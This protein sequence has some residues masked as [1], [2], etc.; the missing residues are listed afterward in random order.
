MT[1]RSTTDQASQL[2]A[3]RVAQQRVGGVMSPDVEA[4][5]IFES[6]AT[7]LLLKP[8]TA[9]LFALLARNGLQ[10]AIQTELAQIVDLQSAV[11]DLANASLDVRD[12][13]ELQTAI[14]ALSQLEQLSK[15]SVDSLQFKKF[16]SS[17]SN[18]LDGLSKGVKRPGAT[19]L[20]RPGSEALQD[21]L[22]GFI[23]LDTLHQDTIGRLYD[24][25]VG[26][27]NFLH[28]PLSTIIGLITASRARADIQDIVDSLDSTGLLPADRDLV[29]RLI[30]NRA[31]VKT[32]GNLP[33]LS[34]PLVDSLSSLPQGYSLQAVSDP[35]APSITGSA[36]PFTL[37]SAA[38]IS[39]SDG[40]SSIGPINFPQTTS[41][42]NNKAAIVSQAISYPITIAANYYLFLVV[43]GTS[44]KF[45]PFATGSTSLL[46]FLTQL[47]SF[48]GASSLAGLL[49]ATEFIEPGTSRVLIYHDSASQLSIG[50][51][52]IAPDSELIGGSEATTPAMGVYDNSI[53]SQLGFNG[54]EVGASGTT[55]IQF[56]VD[57]LTQLSSSIV[58]VSQTSDK[59]IVVTGLLTQPGASLTITAPTVL[60]ITGTTQAVSNII[61]LYGSINGVTTDPVNPTLLVDVGDIV[62]APSGDSTVQSISATRI[63]LSNSLPTFDGNIRIDSLLVATYNNL[64]NLLSPVVTSFLNTPFAKDLTSLSLALSSLGNGSPQAQR[65]V[66]IQL[67][68]QLTTSLNSVLT[69]ITDSSTILP[70]SAASEEWKIVDGIET[71]LIERKFDKALDLFLRCDIQEAL[72][73]TSETAS[74]GG[75]LL[76]AASDFARTDIV[77][78][79][80]ALDEQVESTSSQDIKGL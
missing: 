78:P 74:Y 23:S 8:R 37:P 43:D 63:T 77:V 65:N 16:D 70:A 62:A 59:R 13:S 48:I 9:L 64:E 61:R 75:A 31:A 38:T 55:P 25:A 27:K 42:L 19:Q 80:R 5:A 45:G 53:H 2:L 39:I 47:T 32:L 36:G 20:T 18:F 24:L 69:A 51:I 73:S 15:I 26:I 34:D 76:K 21:L 22:T 68:S 12:P 1:V 17:I 72:N 4:A 60:G 44:Y 58:S 57:S 56:I 49:H 3:R 71:T 7:N 14:S 66:V 6:I 41:D 52:H 33:N 67:L 10:Q 50:Q 54:T 40:T 35:S 79:N 28:S 29:V 46:S 30:T 11:T